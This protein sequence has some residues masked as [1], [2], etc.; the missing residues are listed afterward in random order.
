[1]SIHRAIVVLILGLMFA[2]CKREQRIFRAEPPVIEAGKASYQVS[3]GEGDRG[4]INN[5]YEE[6]AYSISVGQQLF[7]SFN[8]VGCH[9]H[10]GGGM[11]PA[12]MD[13]KWI[14]G[15][16]PAQIYA[17]IMYGRPNGMPAF[18]GKIRESQA[19]ELAAYVRSLSGLTNSGAESGRA[20]HMKG[21]TPPNSVPVTTPHKASLPASAER[22]K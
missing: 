18:A 19:W 6:N 8:C 17:S 11:G 21:P 9:A 2:A 14:Y 15:S 12:L 16:E 4:Q 7:Q 10:G 20:D 1:M 3:G 22:P 5:W 13:D